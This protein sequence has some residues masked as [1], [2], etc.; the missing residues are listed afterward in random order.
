[1]EE[2]FTRQGDTPALGGALGSHGTFELAQGEYATALELL[3][4]SRAITDRQHLRRSVAWLDL[5]RVDALVALGEEE[6]AQALLEQVTVEMEQLGEPGGAEA[7]ADAKR[8][9]SHH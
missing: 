9:W 3:E 4:R 2:R 7:C 1:V 6:R 5:A 8:A